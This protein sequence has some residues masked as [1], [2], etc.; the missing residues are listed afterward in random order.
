M[1]AAASWYNYINRVIAKDSF[2]LLLLLT[3]WCWPG[4]FFSWCCSLAGAC[5]GCPVWSP[6]WSVPVMLLEALGRLIMARIS[7]SQSSPPC[8]SRFCQGRLPVRNMHFLW[9]EQEDSCSCWGLPWS[10]SLWWL[11]LWVAGLCEGA[12]SAIRAIIR[13]QGVQFSIPS[14]DSIQHRFQHLAIHLWCVNAELWLRRLTTRP[15]EVNGV[16]R[17]FNFLVQL[18]CYYICSWEC[19]FFLRKGCGK[20]ILTFWPIDNLRFHYG[21]PLL[22]GLVHT[23]KKHSSLT[24]S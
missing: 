10:S 24:R 15:P 22:K 2:R 3:V 6:C 5:N 18:F 9:C 19:C 23:Q 4:L 16:V 14:L 13:L 21:W 17:L 7:M 1:M 11:N 8:N 12:V 20:Y